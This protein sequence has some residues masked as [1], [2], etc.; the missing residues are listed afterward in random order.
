[1]LLEQYN[2]RTREACTLIRDLPQATLTLT[3]AA[4]TGSAPSPSS[5]R[6]LMAHVSGS[7]KPR[8]S[9]SKVQWRPTEPLVNPWEQRT[10]KQ[11]WRSPLENQQRFGLHRPV[12]ALPKDRLSQVTRR[13]MISE[14]RGRATPHG[15]ANQGRASHTEGPIKSGMNRSP[16]R[17]ASAGRR[18][19]SEEMEREEM[20]RE[21]REE[22]EASSSWNTPLEIAKLPDMKGPKTGVAGLSGDEEE[23]E[24]EE[25][26]E[27][28]VGMSWL[29]QLSDSETSNL[30]RI[31]WAEIERLVATEEI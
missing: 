20:E 25:E 8:N 10:E 4:Q 7:S 15:P 2:Q 6:P 26:E 5:V 11:R 27:G 13:G 29:D 19:R 31:D 24:E 3:R 17:A 18:E 22:M 28:T 23:E 30:S 16:S 9:S 1:M 21:E 14:A 12:S